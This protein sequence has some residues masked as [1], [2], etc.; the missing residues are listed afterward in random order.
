MEQASLVARAAR[1]AMM[2]RDGQD[3][4]NHRQ[5]AED[6][7]RA[8]GSGVNPLFFVIFGPLML[9]SFVLCGEDSSLR[10]WRSSMDLDLDPADRREFG[11]ILRSRDAVPSPRLAPAVLAWAETTL[12]QGRCRWDRYL[13]WAW[14][15]WISAGVVTAIAWGTPRDVAIHL[16]VFDVML[17]VAN[18]G[19][20]SHRRARA[21]LAAAGRPM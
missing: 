10:G 21:L 4:T 7:E 16:I 5:P 11:K 19:R 15:L 14:V 20:M 18:L 13:N 12:R 17:H 9:A 3:P 6:E 8:A 2:R 1:H